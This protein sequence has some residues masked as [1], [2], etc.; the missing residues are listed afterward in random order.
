M[1]STT[2]KLAAPSRSPPLLRVARQTRSTTSE[3]LRGC[4]RD[5]GS[6]SDSIFPTRGRPAAH[7]VPST[8]SRGTRRETSDRFSGWSVGVWI[9]T[10]LYGRYFFSSSAVARRP[11]STSTASKVSSTACLL[12]VPADTFL[13]HLFEHTRPPGP[14]PR[15]NPRTSNWVRG[16]H[17][18][19][20]SG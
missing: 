20:C 13:I 16:T 7:R 11:P 4:P 6:S 5:A 18:L 2:S 1:S 10:S 9:G 3:G 15:A 17:L 12:C 19:E 8:V 14:R